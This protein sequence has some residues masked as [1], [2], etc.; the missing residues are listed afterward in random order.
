MRDAVFGPLVSP[1]AAAQD[2]GTVQS[3][4]LGT[5]ADA[6]P[7]RAD[8]VPQ[9]GDQ[10]APTTSGALTFCTT[11]HNPRTT[12]NLALDR[13]VCRR[14]CPRMAM[15]IIIGPIRSPE[16]DRQQPV[17]PRMPKQPPII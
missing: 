10:A 2:D 8:G 12:E 1:T 16:A 4:I 11:F 15:Q 17:P 13:H 3:P 7:R 6:G 14:V 5:Y 9:A